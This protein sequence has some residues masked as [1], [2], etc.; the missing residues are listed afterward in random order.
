MGTPVK[1]FNGNLKRNQQAHFGILNIDVGKK[2]LQQC[3]DAVC[4]LELNI[5]FLNICQKKYLIIV[6]KINFTHFNK[7]CVY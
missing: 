2:D 5:Y 4:V 6:L 7:Y 1:L 3:A